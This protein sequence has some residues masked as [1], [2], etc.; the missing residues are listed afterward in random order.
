LLRLLAFV[1]LAWFDGSGT[2][3]ATVRGGSIC[4]SEATTLPRRSKRPS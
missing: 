2:P 4:F 1:L 3:H